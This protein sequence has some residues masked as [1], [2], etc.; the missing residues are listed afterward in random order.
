MSSSLLLSVGTG[1]TEKR[2]LTN[3]EVI[4]LL[5]TSPKIKRL[6]G[7]GK[8]ADFVREISFGESGRSSARSPIQCNQFFGKCNEVV[9]G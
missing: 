3:C 6:S 5:K 9:G 8:P 7:G 4:I 1:L 2:E